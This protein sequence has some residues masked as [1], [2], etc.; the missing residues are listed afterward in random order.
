MSLRFGGL[1]RKRMCSSECHWRAAA[2]TSNQRP[3]AGTRDS[4]LQR[5]QTRLSWPKAL[6]VHQ[7]RGALKTPCVSYTT[8]AVSLRMSNASAAAA[9]AA[10]AH[11][12]SSR[13]G[14]A[15]FSA[16]HLQKL[17]D[18]TYPKYV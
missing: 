9:N 14:T 2:A 12:C 11:P 8:T 13:L 3:S 10:C 15:S 1:D 7:T 5:W 16:S 4:L 18:V 6:K 17:Y